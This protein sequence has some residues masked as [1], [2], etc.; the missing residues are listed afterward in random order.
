M[1]FI[2]M[3]IGPFYNFYEYN[4]FIN[5]NFEDR[6]LKRDIPKDFALFGLSLLL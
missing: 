5:K 4:H 1:N 2:G 3:I 6:K